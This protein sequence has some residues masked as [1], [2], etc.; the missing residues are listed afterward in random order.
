MELATVAGTTA[1]RRSRHLRD[2]APP[3]MRH[4]AAMVA[5]ELAAS[6]SARTGTTQ[7]AYRDAAGD[8]P[9]E[10]AATILVVDVDQATTITQHDADRRTRL[11]GDVSV[12]EQV[13]AHGGV[14]VDA[15]GAR[16]AAAFSSV[17]CALLCA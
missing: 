3:S 17:R 5:A 6:V 9:Q 4:A 2:F 11:V 13:A 10:G 1:R 7:P 8:T 12:C 15:A 14:E 16:F